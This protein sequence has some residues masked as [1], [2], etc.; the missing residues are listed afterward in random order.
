MRFAFINNFSSSGSLFLQASKYDTDSPGQE[1][2]AESCFC[3]SSKSL[4]S[5]DPNSDEAAFI[6]AFSDG[7][8]MMVQ[9]AGVTNLSGGNGIQERY[10]QARVLL[11]W[12][13]I[14]SAMIRT[15]ASGAGGSTVVALNTTDL[16]RGSSSLSLTRVRFSSR[17]V[18]S[19]YC[20]AIGAAK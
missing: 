7:G 18:L 15:W 5:L 8:S 14:V 2:A 12:P 9:F 19:K 11:R 6:S 13:L 3:L 16:I 20:F 4:I 1:M 17:S 10:Y